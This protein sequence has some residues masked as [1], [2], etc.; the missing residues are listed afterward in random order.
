MTCEDPHQYKGFSE[1][2]N[3]Q[4]TMILSTLKEE[5]RVEEKVSDRILYMNP[6]YANL[7]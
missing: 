4:W 5:D 6:Q 3:N 1:K 2:E 7:L